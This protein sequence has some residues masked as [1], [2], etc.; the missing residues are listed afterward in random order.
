MIATSSQI[1]LLVWLRTGRAVSPASCER[2]RLGSDLQVESKTGV[3]LLDDDTRGTLDGL[4]AN[5]THLWERERQSSAPLVPSRE[6]SAAVPSRAWGHKVGCRVVWGRLRVGPHV[7]RLPRPASPGPAWLRRPP[8]LLTP[9]SGSPAQPFPLFPFPSSSL[10]RS[11]TPVARRECVVNRRGR[12]GKNLSCRD[13]EGV[14]GTGLGGTDER[15]SK[16]AGTAHLRCIDGRLESGRR[17]SG[18]RLGCDGA[19]KSGREM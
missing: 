8:T 6:G 16:Q 7:A 19:P 9:A 3:V 2:A 17:L 1:F 4:G 13:A 14:G 10:R 11:S 15:G 12:G 18:G 5:A